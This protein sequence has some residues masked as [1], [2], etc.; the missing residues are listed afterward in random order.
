MPTRAV[1]TAHRSLDSQWTVGH[2]NKGSKKSVKIRKAR[3]P[4]NA[5]ATRQH[6]PSRDIRAGNNGHDTLKW[7]YSF[8]ATLFV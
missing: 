5:L 3:L 1:E 4:P 8:Y 7:P 6:R 2:G